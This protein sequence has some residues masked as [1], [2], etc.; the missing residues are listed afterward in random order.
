MDKIDLSFEYS[1]LWDDESLEGTANASL[2]DFL[3]DYQLTPQVINKVDQFSYNEE[4]ML[5]FRVDKFNL[6]ASR[7]PIKV[8]GSRKDQI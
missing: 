5:H 4:G 7:Y 2:Y 3:A 8:S 6:S 1:F